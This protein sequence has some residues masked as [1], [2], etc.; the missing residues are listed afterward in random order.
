MAAR[1]ALAHQVRIRRELETP[2]QEGTPHPSPPTPLLGQ[3]GREGVR[4]NSF[5]GRQ[6]R[7]HPS[8]SP[9]PPPAPADRAPAL[10]PLSG[11]L[12]PRL[13]SPDADADQRPRGRAAAGTRGASGG[14]AASR[15]RPATH[16]GR[17][18]RLPASAGNF[19]GPAPRQ[20]PPSEGFAAS[21]LRLLFPAPTRAGSRHPPG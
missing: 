5:R 17:R 3:D 10:L 1:A 4:G 6:R 2:P 7:S 20:A 11:S 16:S 15:P 14:L 21:I 19:P 13:R 9:Y 8:P 12:L 18:A